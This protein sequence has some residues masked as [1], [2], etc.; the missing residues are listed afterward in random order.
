MVHVSRAGAGLQFRK[1]VHIAMGIAVYD[2]KIDKSVNDTMRR[3][4][5]IM[6]DNKRNQKRA[7]WKGA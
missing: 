1:Q 7:G 2:P 3:A 6:Y 5:R 4:D